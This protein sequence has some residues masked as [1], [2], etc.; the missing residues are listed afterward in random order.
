MIRILRGLPAPELTRN[1]Y[2]FDA[3]ENGDAL[4]VQS[5]ASAIEMFRR[6]KKKSGRDARLVKTTQPNVL[7]FIEPADSGLALIERVEDEV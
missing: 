6:W 2:P 1:K 7:F 3:L 4:E 5:V